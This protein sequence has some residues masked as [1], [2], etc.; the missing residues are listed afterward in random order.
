MQEQTARGAGAKNT[1]RMGSRSWAR[2][3]HKS[4]LQLLEGELQR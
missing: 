1:V 3:C 2:R 4:S